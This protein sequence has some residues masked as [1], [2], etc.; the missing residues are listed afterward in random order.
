MHLTSSDGRYT[1]WMQGDGNLV[2]YGPSGRAQWANH[3][4]SSS[5]VVMQGDGNLVTYGGSG[6]TWAS[7]TWG[8]GADRL[9]VQSDG[10]LVLYAGSRPVWASNTA[11][12]T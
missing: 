7:N 12:R 6:A 3:R 9:V 10:N 1:L 5:F 8:S 4:F 2:L 11:G